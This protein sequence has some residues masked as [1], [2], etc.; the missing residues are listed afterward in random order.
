M[1][2]TIRV[3][4][5]TRDRI[6]ALARLTGQPMTAVIDEA[7]DALERRRFFE[8]FNNRYAELRRDDDV[9]AEIE[10]E[11]AAEAGALRDSSA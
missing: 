4:V 10:A 5:A 6:A 1:S 2:T 7:M 9:W 8:Q 3:D 11:R